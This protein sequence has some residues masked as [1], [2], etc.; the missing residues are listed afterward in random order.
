MP[1]RLRVAGVGA[2]FFSDFQYDAWARMPGVELA[3]VCD[4]DAERAAAMA[5]RHGAGASY[6]ELGRMLDAVQPDLL[7]IA[8]PPAAHFDIIRIGAERGIG[9]ICQK[10][11]CA[12]LE[13]ARRAV[14][15]CAEADTPL[16]VHENF[17]FQPWYRKIASML[18]EGRLGEIY[19]ASFR[20]RPG[21]GQGADA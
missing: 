14:K 2:G 9:M 16:V 18:D 8:V 5:A 11:F 21:D 3:A 7:D 4:L 6:T 20:L 15:L 19:Q 10:P 13:T 1:A 17:R 12:T